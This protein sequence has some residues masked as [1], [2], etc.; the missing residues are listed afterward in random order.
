M[1]T[2]EQISGFEKQIEE[3]LGDQLRRLKMVDAKG[4]KN[5]RSLQQR[6]IAEI[7]LE[8]D[9]DV[10]TPQKEQKYS[11]DLQITTTEF[12]LIFQDIE[13]THRKL[14]TK[15][16]ISNIDDFLTFLNIGYSNNVEYAEGADSA[17]IFGMQFKIPLPFGFN[18]R[19]QQNHK[20]IIAQINKRKDLK[21][22]IN[23]NTKFKSLYGARI[24]FV[25]NKN[26]KKIKYCAMSDR[27]LRVDRDFDFKMIKKFRKKKNE[28]KR[29]QKRLRIRIEKDPKLTDNQKE[30]FNNEYG[31]RVIDPTIPKIYTRAFDKIEKMK[32]N[33]SALFTKANYRLLFDENSNMAIQEEG[34]A[35][36]R[37]FT[38]YYRDKNNLVTKEVGYYGSQKGYKTEY[39]NGKKSKETNYYNSTGEVASVTEHLNKLGK[40]T[41][42]VTHFRKG[43][44]IE[45]VEEG[46]VTSFYD[47]AGKKVVWQRI[48]EGDKSYSVMNGVDNKPFGLLDFAR[49]KNPEIT[50]NQYLDLL[51]KNLNTPEKLHIF[52]E[53]YMQYIHDDPAKRGEDYTAPNINDN[54]DYWQ[55]AKETINRIHKGKMCGDCDDYAFLARE[56]LRRQGKNAYV[57]MIPGH[58]ICVW[59]E[60]RKDGNWNAYSI[61]TFGLDKNGNRYGMKIDPKKNRGYTDLQDAVNSLMP[62]YDKGGLGLDNGTSYRISSGFIAILDVP[63]KGSSDLM[64]VPLKAI[65]GSTKVINK[66]RKAKVLNNTGKHW[67][68]IS[69]YEE[70]IKS[71]SKNQSFYHEEIN[72]VLDRI[73][74]N[75]NKHDF[76][77][78]LHNLLILS[79]KYPKTSMYYGSIAEVFR[80]GIKNNIK[81]KK[82]Y[83]L[84]IKNG[85]KNFGIYKGLA[86]VYEKEK[87]IDKYIATLELGIKKGGKKVLMRNYRTL[88]MAYA[89]YN[90]LKKIQDMTMSDPNNLKLNEGSVRAYKDLF[91]NGYG[92]S[93]G[94]VDSI[95]I[96]YVRSNPK[97]KKAYEMWIG[98]LE[99]VISMKTDDPFFYETLAKIYKRNGEMVKAASVLQKA[100]NHPGNP[101]GSAPIYV[102]L[103]DIYIKLGQK[104]NATKAYEL[105]KKN[106]SVKE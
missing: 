18:K 4:S 46:N 52:F 81:A 105:M 48:K 69:A 77:N 61:G 57:I 74:P 37:N 78:K 76:A 31:P 16:G 19:A 24:E 82:Y 56:I 1:P 15:N 92:A 3:S 42:K 90:K 35:Y 13:K 96:K 33:V 17:E 104:E 54:K 38:L 8:R 55:T 79:K 58:A 73:Y 75:N 99:K 22:Y 59:L 101:K 95:N 102:D 9:D 36:E 32:L 27:I 64:H 7:K 12:R 23:S 20:K 5:V 25:I 65:A 50:D 30:N 91:V 85:Y 41:K 10:N 2:P 34:S 71:D 98:Q 67:Q 100:A 29:I 6:I 72:D 47:K 84:A 70:L 89:K 60:K 103:I 44:T 93:Y 26:G 62:K 97:V 53:T 40:K 66:I 106:M 14:L 28:L 39:A 51:A 11:A 83:K 87:D 88:G 68:A 86:L 80:C 43:G 94:G 49:K 63:K 21:P 45:Y